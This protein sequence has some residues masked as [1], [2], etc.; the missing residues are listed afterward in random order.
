MKGK[1]I[2][3]RPNEPL[4]RQEAAVGM[5]Q[6]MFPYYTMATPMLDHVPVNFKEVWLF[7]KEGYFRVSYYE[8]NL[9][10]ITRAV[11]DLC[12]AGFPETWQEEWEQIEKEILL[13]SKTLVGKDMEP[14]SDKELMDCYE[15]M[16]ALDMKMWSLSI[17]I[18]AFDIGADRIEMERISSE[19][20]FSEEEIQTL[21]TPLI[22]SFI[23]AWEFALEKVAEGDMTQEELRDEFYWY[24]VSYSDLVEVD[25]A[26]I[27]E[28][29]ANRHAAA[30]HSPLEEEKEILVRYGLEENPLALFRTLTTWRDDR[31]KLNYVGLYGLVKI[32]REILRRNDIPLAYA[33]ALLPSQ[34]PDVLS[35]R[36]TAPDIER[37]YREG[38]FVHMTPDNEF[39]YAFG[40]E[41]EEYW[42]MVE[43]AYAETMRSDEVTEIKGVIASKGTA[44]GRAR[45]LLDFNDSKAASFQKGEILITSMTRP[46][47]LPLMKLSGAIVTNEGGITSHAAIVSRELKIPCII[48]TKNATQ[49]FKDGDLVEVDANTG[50]VRKL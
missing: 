8:K 32:K 25:D 47:F 10:A 29:L 12:A 44:T 7:Y 18:D 42:G 9:E 17:F 28:A 27:D 33:N 6:V 23:T 39:T 43:S 3:I 19:F 40:P 36:L 1:P 22:P 13:E 16:F 48:G 30:F 35:G 15:R 49:V 31:K 4:Y 37:Q 50:I 2:V 41:A 24:G 46:E 21:T 20:G 34:I 45:I 38:I 14:L 26:F 11:L 5:Y